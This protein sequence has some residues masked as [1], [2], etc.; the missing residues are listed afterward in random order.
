MLQHQQTVFAGAARRVRSRRDALGDFGLGLSLSAAAASLMFMAMLVT[1]QSRVAALLPSMGAVSA[2]LETQLPAAVA[3]QFLYAYVLLSLF[4]RVVRRGAVAVV[5]TAAVAVAVHLTAPGTTA[6][7][8]ASVAAT[9]LAGGAAFIA[10]G[11]LWMPIALSYGWMLFE[12]PIFGF[13][14]GGLPVHSPW[15]RQEML[16]YTVWS[17]G[18]HGPDAS[19]FGI[20]AKLIMAGAV[21]AF[22]RKDTP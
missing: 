13:A 6:F 17:G 8:A 12:G 14:S 18:V 15:F 5:L 20:A 19:I 22:A 9:T 16:Q 21:L 2:S 1:R 3:S 10:T 7:T 4:V 11:R